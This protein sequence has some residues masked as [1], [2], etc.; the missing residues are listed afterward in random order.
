MGD[1]IDAFPLFDATAPSSVVTRASSDSLGHSLHDQ[2]FQIDMSVDSYGQQQQ[3]DSSSLTGSDCS[4]GQ[5]HPSV[6]QVSETLYLDLFLQSWISFF[7]AVTYWHH[8]SEGGASSVSLPSLILFCIF[9]VYV[10]M[11]ES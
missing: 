4:L 3:Q 2:S 10:L 7:G 8:S 9:W 5:V 11:G 6:E 1:S